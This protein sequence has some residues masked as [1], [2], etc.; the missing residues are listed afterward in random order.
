MRYA[1]ALL[2]VTSGCRMEGIEL[3]KETRTEE[4]IKS[5]IV[6]FHENGTS[7]DALLYKTVADTCKQIW[8]GV[9]PS[10]VPIVVQRWMP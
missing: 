9:E 1:L 4:C 10:T 7:G 3:S 8:M 5:H 2:V 6:S